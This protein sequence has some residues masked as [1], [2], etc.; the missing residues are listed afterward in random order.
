MIGCLRDSSDAQVQNGTPGMLK[1]D[2]RL[3]AFHAVVVHGSFREAADSLRLSQQGV[4]FLIKTLEDEL[5]TRLLLRQQGKGIELTKTGEIL[6]RYAKQIVDLYSAAEDAI[7]QQSGAQGGALNV[8]ATGSIA[9][10]CLPLG[11][12]IFLKA[13][14]NVSIS[15]AVSNSDGIADLLARG[16]VDVGI[17]SGGPVGLDSFQVE[18]FFE[19][20]LVFVSHPEHPLAGR[21]NLSI[22]ELATASFVIREPGSGTR[23]LMDSHLQNNGLDPASLRIAV[24]L[25]STESVKAAVRAGVGLSMVSRLSLT[26]AAETG[27]RILKV[28]A[29]PLRRTFYIVQPRDAYTRRLTAA[30]VHSLKTP[31]GV[32]TSPGTLAR[33][34]SGPGPD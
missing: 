21:E 26:G 8:G 34:P 25:G 15:V 29:L 2:A 10:F 32:E 4:S 11:I 7:A 13:H 1:K 30:F 9:Q 24:T 28:D 22:D 19:D 3:R 23:R 16:A 5:G 12:A 33:A 27:V 31:A 14:L 6:F 17:I 20:E 18:P